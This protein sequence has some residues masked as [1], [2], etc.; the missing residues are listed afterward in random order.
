M[1]TYRQGDVLLVRVGSIPEGA[2]ARDR[3]GPL[4][5]A[6]GEAT[7]HAHTI[8]E[9]TARLLDHEQ[10]TYLEVAD[11]LAM[12]THQE[13][14]AIAIPAGVYEVRRQREYSPEAI[15]NVAD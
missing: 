10:A 13:H 4:V 8:A 3:N 11:A 15:R 1:T 6:H 5:L 12:L 14:A 2:K 9:P 7:G